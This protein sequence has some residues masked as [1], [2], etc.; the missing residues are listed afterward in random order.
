LQRVAGEFIVLVP[1]THILYN[2]FYKIIFANNEIALKGFVQS[3]I[4]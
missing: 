2:I 4:R 3:I 1:Y